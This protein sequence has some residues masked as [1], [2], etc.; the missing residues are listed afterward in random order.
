MS[1]IVGGNAALPHRWEW[2]GGLYYKDYAGDYQFV[3]G[4][5]LI[6]ENVFVTAAHCVV[7]RTDERR[8][9]VRLGDHDRYCTVL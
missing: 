9:M 3:C 5:S 1:R 6:R 4:G 8:M 7:R 2:Q